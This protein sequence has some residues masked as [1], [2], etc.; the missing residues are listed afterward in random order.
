MERVK[1]VRYGLH[2][3]HVHIYIYTGTYCIYILQVYTGTGTGTG[4][5]QYME[6]FKYVQYIPL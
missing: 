5:V 3:L 1:L 4:T 2:I 6:I